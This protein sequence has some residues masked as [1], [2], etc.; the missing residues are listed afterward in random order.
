MNF[1]RG[2]GIDGLAGIDPNR[3]YKN[4]TRRPLLNASRADLLAYAKQHGLAWREDASNQTD[5]YQ[6]NAIRHHLAPVFREQFGLNDR[7]LRR[8]MERLRHGQWFH[9]YGLEERG[10][11]LCQVRDGVLTV[12]RS[13]W[14]NDAELLYFLQ[15]R[16]NTYHLPAGAFGQFTD[17]QF[18]QIVA[19]Q[20]S[21][22]I[23]GQVGQAEINSASIRFS[24]PSAEIKPLEPVT[25]SEY[26]RSY[27]SVG[28]TFSV[29]DRP[30]DLTS[31][32]TVMYSRLFNLP[33]HLRPRKNGDR[34][35]PLGMS[36][37]SK[38]V[39]DMLIDAKLPQLHRESLYL[40]TDDNDNILAIPGLI[41][42]EPCRIDP[43]DNQVLRIDLVRSNWFT[44]PN[45]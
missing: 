25:I 12:Q 34:M 31:S 26:N 39:K 22:V 3:K 4:F 24:V 16:I 5:D 9:G 43:E 1:I 6:R 37:H 10:A 19:V 38:K 41:A 35:R 44:V 11:A 21:G 32:R 2:T 30:S 33:L 29:V 23:Y 7:T 20:G 18:R 42:G 45:T 17:E 8:N 27:E 14:R 13:G 28:M 36:G 15:R 40:L